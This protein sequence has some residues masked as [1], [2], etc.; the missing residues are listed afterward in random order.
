MKRIRIACAAFAFV[1]SATAQVAHAQ[2]VVFDPTN[3]IQYFL[4]A[5]R[6]LEQVNNQIRQL[7]NEAQMLANMARNLTSL[8][9]SVLGELRTTIA[10]TQRLI[11][12][13]RGMA[14]DVS[15]LESEFARLYPVQYGATITGAGMAADARERWLYSLEALRTTMTMQAQAAQN[16][17][18]DES[19][20]VDLVNRSQAAEGALQ[21]AQATNQLLALHAQ[22]AIQQQQLRITQERASALEQAR[23]VASEE[24]SRELR[25]RFLGSGT[26]YTPAS[27]QFSAN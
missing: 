13:A 27:V 6:T 5:V 22:Q 10:A 12:E 4:T 17:A 20:L 3:Y 16:L 8:D 18:R 7:Q 26:P 14:F 23:A 15:R 24:R 25:R 11:A 2:W 21:A 9:Q 19:V 1:I